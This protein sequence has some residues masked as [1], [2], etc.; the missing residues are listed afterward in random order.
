MRKSA[1]TSG[2]SFVPLIVLVALSVPVSSGGRIS[3]AS[4]VAMSMSLRV[5]VSASPG[6]PQVPS[7]AICCVPLASFSPS[8][9]TALFA[10]LIAGCE[11]CASCQLTFCEVRFSCRRCTS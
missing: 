9:A 3:S 4:T 6:R 1:S 2:F 10:Y 11:S 8:T 5:T 7:A